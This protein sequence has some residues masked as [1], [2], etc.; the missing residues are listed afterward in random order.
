MPRPPRYSATALP[1]KTVSCADDE[2]TRRIAEPA[3]SDLRREAFESAVDVLQS[4]KRFEGGCDAGTSMSI[5][6]TLNLY[7]W[8][9]FIALAVEIFFYW[10]A[11]VIQNGT[12]EAAHHFICYC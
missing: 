4:F 10:L 2:H 6:S 5:L 1:T 8:L 12:V 3:R 11:R 9:S 7:Y